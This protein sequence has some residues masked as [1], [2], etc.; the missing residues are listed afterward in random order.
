MREEIMGLKQRWNHLMRHRLMR[1]RARV[2][3]RIEHLEEKKQRH[4]ATLTKTEPAPVEPS[5]VTE[6]TIPVTEAKRPARRRSPRRRT[7]REA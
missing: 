6:P 2:D 3:R 7:P 4:D 5:P 1:L